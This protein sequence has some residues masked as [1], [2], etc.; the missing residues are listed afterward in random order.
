MDIQ[1]AEYEVVADSINLLNNKVK[2]VHIGTHSES[3]EHELHKI[4]IKNG[5]VEIF[6][7]G[8]NTTAPT[9]F[10]DIKFSDGV[11]SWLNPR[12]VSK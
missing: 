12:L 1:G 4:F 7:F 11:Q 8:T 10:G 5:W 2:R 3:I 9:G 6:N